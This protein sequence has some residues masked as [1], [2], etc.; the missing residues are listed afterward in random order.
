MVARMIECLTPPV[1]FRDM[2]AGRL[3]LGSFAV[4]LHCPVRLVVFSGSLCACFGV[5]LF[6]APWHGVVIMS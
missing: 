2:T 6:M 1:C 4:C 5:G 3:E